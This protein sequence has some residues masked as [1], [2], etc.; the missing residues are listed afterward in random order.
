[1]GQRTRLPRAEARVHE[2]QATD[3]A[4][5]LLV[6]AVFVLLALALGSG[7]ALLLPSAL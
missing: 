4:V 2:A 3:A 6:A 1:M 5:W 7:L